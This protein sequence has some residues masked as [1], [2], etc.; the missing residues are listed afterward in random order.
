MSD[1]IAL[2]REELERALKLTGE[3]AHADRLGELVFD[4]LGR[5]AEGGSLFVGKKYVSGRA[6]VYAVE[7][8]AAE[9]PL[10]NMLVALERGPDGSQQRALLSVLFVRG[11]GLAV[12]AR[13]DERKSLC[14]RFAAHC[15]WLELQSSYRVLWILPRVLEPALCGDVHAE[16]AALVL[17]DDDERPVPQARARNAG[18]IAALADAPGVPAREALERIESAAQDPFSRT[19]CALALGHETPGLAT[20]ARVQGSVTRFPRGMLVS[21]LSWIS[22]LALLRFALRGLFSVV[23]FRREA[24]VELC[25]ETLR[26]RKHAHLLGRLVRSS[27]QVHPLGQLCFARRNTRYPALRFVLGAV[28]FALGILL[29]GLFAFDALRVGDPALG[30]IAAVLLLSGAA[31]DLVFEVLLPGRRGKVALDL[32]LEERER[33]RIA[34]VPLADADA[35]LSALARRLSGAHRLSA[36][37][38]RSNRAL[39]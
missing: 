7:R 19:L 3:L 39:A 12:K 17:R 22:G 28:C 2:S 20:E 26:V 8:T 5:Q 4:V 36:D 25:G 37:V 14:A 27:E 13:P 10:G 9:T 1:A 38:R 6:K 31:L 18:R 15:D 21:V 23:G 16:L 30:L 35:M 32:M 29:G 33:V 11:F 24:E 34:G